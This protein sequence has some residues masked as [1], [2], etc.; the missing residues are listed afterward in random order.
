MSYISATGF[1]IIVSRGKWTNFL[2]PSTQNKLIGCCLLVKYHKL[3][4]TVI[5]AK[6]FDYVECGPAILVVINKFRFKFI[7]RT[8]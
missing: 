4:L 5:Q 8:E 6:I 3:I 7:S 2:T 1:Y